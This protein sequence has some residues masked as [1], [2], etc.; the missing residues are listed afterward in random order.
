MFVILTLTL[1]LW[2]VQ[3]HQ[4]W[5]LNV[6]LMHNLLTLILF[7]LLAS[8]C[9]AILVVVDVVFP[10]NEKSNTKSQICGS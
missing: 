5:G 1:P 6:G 3:S 2:W 7:R 4:Q 8:V 10:G 9:L